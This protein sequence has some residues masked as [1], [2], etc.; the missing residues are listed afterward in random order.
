MRRRNEDEPE[1]S[2]KAKKRKS[3]TQKKPSANKLEE[4]GTSGEGGGGTSG[5]GRVSG[6]A[7]KGF[8]WAHNTDYSLHVDRFGKVYAVYDGSS[9]NNASWTIWVPKTPCVDM[10]ESFSEQGT[11]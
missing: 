6:C 10:R 4:A 1:T 8:A 3:R 7:S 5:R 11:P 9:I 2:S